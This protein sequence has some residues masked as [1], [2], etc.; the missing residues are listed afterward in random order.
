MSKRGIDLI[1]NG[2]RGHCGACDCQHIA[3]KEACRS[4][5]TA[6]DDIPMRQSFALATEGISTNFWFAAA[7]SSGSTRTATSQ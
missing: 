1:L 5:C 3:D 6:R 2:L 4:E 7:S